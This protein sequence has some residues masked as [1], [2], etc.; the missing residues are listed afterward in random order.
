[1]LV[2]FLTLLISLT[3]RWL[4]RRK[5]GYQFCYAFTGVEMF[6]DTSSIMFCFGIE[7]RI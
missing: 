1:M 4:M 2:L 3:A 6:E 5:S 7:H